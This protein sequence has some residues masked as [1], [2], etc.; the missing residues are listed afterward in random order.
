MSTGRPSAKR[1][2]H[3]IERAD[4]AV[5]DAAALDGRT[6]AARRTGAF[7]ELGDQPPLRALCAVV[8]GAGLVGRDAKLVRTGLRMLAAHGV[9][10]G[11]KSFIKRRVDRTRPG[12]AMSNGRYRMDQGDSHQKRLSS[13]PSGH[14][15]G[16]AAVARAAAREYPEAAPVA[17]ATA[18]AVIAAQ[19]PPKNHFLSDL[20]VGSAI[21]LVSEAAVSAVMSAA[22]KRR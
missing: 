5:A 2:L 11:I 1:T 10:T 19:L 8:I 21:G 12:D 17:G 16:I 22:G 18:A 9:A 14:S 20:A 15:A 3:P 7:A 4:L 6:K 13:M